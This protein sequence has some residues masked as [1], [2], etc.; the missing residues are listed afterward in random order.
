[1][2][3][4]LLLTDPDN[5]PDG[6][7]SVDTQGLFTWMLALLAIIAT[8]VAAYIICKL[9]LKAYPDGNKKLVIIGTVLATI[10]LIVFY[11]LF[12]YFASK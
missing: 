3:F 6:Y 10:V 12:A 5:K 9:Y 4:N 1:M 8:I 11:I 2:I 7:G